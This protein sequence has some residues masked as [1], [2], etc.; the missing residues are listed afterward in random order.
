[1]FYSINQI[2]VLLF[3]FSKKVKNVKIICYFSEKMIK[4]RLNFFEAL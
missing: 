3:F 1:M 4:N 2:V